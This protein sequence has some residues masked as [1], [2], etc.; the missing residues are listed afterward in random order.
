MAAKPDKVV[1]KP[2]PHD[3]AHLH[4]AGSAA[5]TDDLPEP[6]DLLHVAVGLSAK[7]HAKIKAIDLQNVQSAA[8]VVSTCIAADIPGDNNCGTIIADEPLLAIDQ[9]EFAGQPVFAV[10]AETVGQAR[11]AALLASIAAPLQCR[12]RNGATH[13]PGSH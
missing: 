3:S 5:Y 4:V 12:P 11:K 8:G 2:L 7:A 10:A 13:S 6:R 1:G 9:V